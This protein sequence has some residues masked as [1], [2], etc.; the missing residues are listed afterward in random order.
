MPQY[1][2]LT[3]MPVVP[4]HAAGKIDPIRDRDKGVVNT[5][6]IV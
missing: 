1:S 3:F 6:P 2:I 5:S 4:T